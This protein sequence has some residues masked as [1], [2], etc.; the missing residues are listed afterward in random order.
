MVPPGRTT[1][2]TTNVEEAADFISDV[3]VPCRPARQPSSDFRFSSE[4][5]ASAGLSVSRV[6][7]GMAVSWRTA[8][9][10]DV[11]VCMPTAG[12]FRFT[13]GKD[14]HGLA[15]GDS[16]M[17][18][19][20]AGSDIEI[21][22]LTETVVQ[23]PRAV[24]TRIAAERAG[25]EPRQLRFERMLPVSATMNRYWSGLV[26]HLSRMVDD[27]A[28]AG[29]RLLSSALL[30]LAGTALLSVFPNTTMRVDLGSEGA[31]E[32]AVLRR[33]VDYID[34]HAQEP[35]TV[36]K[37]AVASGASPRAIQAAFRRFRGTT[38]TAYL[39]RVRL[40]NVHRELLRADPLQ[41]TTVAAVAARWGFA[42]PGRFAARY[43]AAFGCPPARTLQDGAG[44][45][46]QATPS[47]PSM[48]GPVS[49][50]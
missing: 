48:L 49:R 1:F 5:V 37:V 19:L 25:V 9:F 22:R 30:E 42:N 21:D 18:P 16:V 26:G 20:E 11:L 32:P 41:G 39:T 38:L 2:T 24:V 29:S 27:D 3:F 50:V 13:S 28:V 43:R 17:M 7:L 4:S 10:D 44:R 8:P 36:T 23:V 15:R 33:A 14:E 34:E 12:G 35:V 40:E 46:G 6:E 45:A 47:L 31:V